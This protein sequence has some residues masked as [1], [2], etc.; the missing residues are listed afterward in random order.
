[1]PLPERDIELEYDFPALS[2][3]GYSIRSAEDSSYNCVAF[4]VGDLNNFWYD[5]KVGGYYWPPGC[6]SA[7]TFEGWVQ[8]FLGHGYSDAD[9]ESFEPEFEKIA[10]YGSAS[11]PEHVA[12]QVSSGA[13]V[14]KMGKGHDIE[15][16]DLA[17][18]EGNLAGKIVKI[19]KRKCKDGRRVLE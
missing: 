16:P 1:M 17:S 19:M 14:S 6:A 10:I 18:L 15:H 8:V 7:D 5:I 4:A 3:S 12:R 9:D 13:W 2:L 11:N